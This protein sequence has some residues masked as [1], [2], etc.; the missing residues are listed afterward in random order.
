MLTSGVFHQV[1]FEGRCGRRLDTR[2]AARCRKPREILAAALRRHGW[3]RCPRASRTHW[4]F[5]RGSISPPA[6]PSAEADARVRSQNQ[7]HHHLGSGGWRAGRTGQPVSARVAQGAGRRSFL[8]TPVA[9]IHG[10]QGSRRSVG[11][12]RHPGRVQTPGLVCGAGARA[13]RVHAGLNPRARS[14]PSMQT[15]LT[16]RIAQHRDEDAGMRQIARHDEP[17]TLRP[18]PRAGL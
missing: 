17:A 7:W 10:I 15:L 12:A 1:L 2:E 3:R 4:V 6:C 18:G 14:S 8:F 16:L 9:Q 11:R 5:H 13:D